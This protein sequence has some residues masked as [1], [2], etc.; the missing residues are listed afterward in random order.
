MSDSE[1]KINEL[2]QTEQAPREAPEEAPP[3]EAVGTGT[4][5]FSDADAAKIAMLSAKRDAV[6][7]AKVKA[8]LQA[9]IDAIRQAGRKRNQSTDSDNE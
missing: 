1:G 5:S 7:D 6:K 4:P 8:A 2:D 9:Q 3:P